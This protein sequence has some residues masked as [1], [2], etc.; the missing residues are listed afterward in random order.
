VHS[1]LNESRHSENKAE[2]E[3]LITNVQQINPVAGLLLLE[4]RTGRD[5]MSGPRLKIQE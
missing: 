4:S 2:P 3:C 5:S 1:L